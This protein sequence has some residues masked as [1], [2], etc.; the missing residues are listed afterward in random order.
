MSDAL[1]RLARDRAGG[2]CEYCQLSD[3]LPPLESFHL[4]HIVAR[5]HGGKTEMENLA[6]A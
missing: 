6:W 2:R 4:E 3:S 5:Q 1:R